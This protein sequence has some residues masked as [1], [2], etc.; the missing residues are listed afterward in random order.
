VNSRMTERW[1]D[2][3]GVYGRIARDSIAGKKN[4]FIVAWRDA[5][6]FAECWEPTWQIGRMAVW[7]NGRKARGRRAWTLSRP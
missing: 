2:R 1:D 5:G 6:G 4:C 7:E 3:M